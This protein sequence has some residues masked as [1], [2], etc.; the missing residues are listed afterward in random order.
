MIL[1]MNDRSS[2]QNINEN[3]RNL[4]SITNKLDLMNL[5]TTL[6]PRSRKYTFFLRHMWII[7]K[8]DH[9]LIHKYCENNYVGL[10]LN[11]TLELEN[12]ITKNSTILLKIKEKHFYH[13]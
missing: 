9:K 11:D 4:N 3:I 12:K 6:Y 13:L 5:C 8:T 2:R 10:I 7:M 1:S